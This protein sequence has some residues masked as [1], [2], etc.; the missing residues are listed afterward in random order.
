MLKKLVLGVLFA[1]L[2]LIAFGQ[3]VAPYTV[4][5]DGCIVGRPC[6][7]GVPLP[8][9]NMGVYS[10]DA[11]GC[12]VGEPCPYRGWR[13]KNNTA[14]TT[15]DPR[16][17]NVYETKHKTDG[18]T[19]V[20]GSNART[21]SK[22]EQHIDPS[23]N[24]QF[25]RDKFGKPWVAPLT[26]PSSSETADNAFGPETDEPL[27]LVY[28][29]SEHEYWQKEWWATGGTMKAKS[30][31]SSSA[32]SSAVDDQ[33]SFDE[34]VRERAQRE[35]TA[36]VALIVSRM[37]PGLLAAAAKAAARERCLGMTD[38]NARQECIN[39]AEQK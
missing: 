3:G 34:Y 7:Y 19:D 17:G 8:P 28:A 26:S 27:G 11:D 21:G 13:N 9:P 25:G 1:L 30:A 6:A 2:P 5:A 38:G 16:S 32:E 39:I 4:D 24:L 35:Y 36:S 12:L 37:Q 20:F 23:L 15:V 29:P 33:Q 18:T 14:K 10:V 31:P 22:W